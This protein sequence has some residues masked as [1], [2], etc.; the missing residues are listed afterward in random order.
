LTAQ[1]LYK[2]YAA[3]SG[4]LHYY[5]TWE[6]GAHVDCEFFPDTWKFAVYSGYAQD[7]DLGGFGA[8]PATVPGLRRPARERKEILQLPRP[9]DDPSPADLDEAFKS[10]CLCAAR[11]LKI[12]LQKPKLPGHDRARRDAEGPD[13]ARYDKARL[14]SGDPRSENPVADPKHALPRRKKKR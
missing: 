11:V 5:V 10:L 9:E 1:E 6:L 3:W 14:G 13:K 2:V 7:A 4:Q 12:D 8:L